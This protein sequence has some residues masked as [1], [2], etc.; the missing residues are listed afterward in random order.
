MDEFR[1]LYQDTIIPALE[2]TRGCCSAYLMENLENGEE[3]ISITIWE[4][5]R[6]AEEYEKSGRFEAMIEVVK[7]CYTRLFQWKMSLAREGEKQARTSDDMRIDHYQMVSG[8][9]FS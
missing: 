6:A 8:E 1:A 3:V 2:K 9:E 5:Q 7:H 4:N